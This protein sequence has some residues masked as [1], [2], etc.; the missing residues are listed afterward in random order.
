VENRVRSGSSLLLKLVGFGVVLGG[1][2]LGAAAL[3]VEADASI[4]VLMGVIALGGLLVALVGGAFMALGAL[5]GRGKS[6]G[7]RPSPSPE[8]QQLRDSREFLATR[9]GKHRD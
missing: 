2:A 5:L 4:Q 9:S 1:L 3:M 6:A 8:Q 7:A